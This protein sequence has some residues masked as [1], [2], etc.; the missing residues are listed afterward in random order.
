MLHYHVWMDKV[1]VGCFWLYTVKVGLD[2]KIDRSTARLVAKSY[3]QIFGLD[4]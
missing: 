3:T 1:V 4:Y 2:G